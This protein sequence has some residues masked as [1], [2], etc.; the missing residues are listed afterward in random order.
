MII[1]LIVVGMV[2]LIVAGFVPA[3]GGRIASL[4]GG[5]LLAV[6]LVLLVLHLLGYAVAI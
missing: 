4:C 6:G 1:V 3:P 2:L 5:V